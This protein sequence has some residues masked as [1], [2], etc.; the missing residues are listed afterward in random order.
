[1]PLRDDILDPIP[2]DNP[3]GQNLRLRPT[4]DRV[5]EARRE[6]DSLAQGAWRRERKLAD[7][8]MAIRVLQEALA[9]ESKDLQLAAWLCDSLLK[10]EGIRGLRDGI[11]FCQALLERYWDTL[12]PLI[13]D[14]DLDDRVAPFEWVASKLPIGIR[15]LPLCR[16]GFSFLEYTD[17]R[18]IEYEEQAKSKDQKA[19][20]EKALKDGKLAPELF[21][22]SFAETPKAFYADLEMQFDSAVEAVGR[23]NETCAARF[24]HRAAP[25]FTKL[26]DALQEVR[27]V[28]HQLLQKKREIEPDAAEPVPITASTP[29]VRPEPDPV[30]Q[31]A[32]TSPRP[33]PPSAQPALFSAQSLPDSAGDHHETF[34]VIAAAAAALRRRDPFSPAPYLLLRGLRWGELRGSHDPAALE[35]PPREVRRQIKRLAL[36]NQWREMLELAENVM[37]FPYSGAWLDLQRFVVE[38]CAALGEEYNNIAIAI[39]SEIRTLLRDLPQLMDAI[40]NDDTPAA[41]SETQVWLKELLNEPAAP[42][43]QSGAHWFTPSEDTQVPGWRRKYVDAHLRALE[44]MQAGEVPAAIRI[45]QQALEQQSS[46]RGRFR[47]KLQL[48]QLCLSA[49]KDAIAQP[50]LDDIAAEIEAHKLDDWEERELVAGALAFLLQSS[51]RVQADAKTK[52]AMFERIC[53]LDPAKAMSI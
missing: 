32:N 14:G 39:R 19:S 7:H 5:R 49:G 48:A 50:L 31:S 29:A 26:Q 16:A 51:K 3:S 13:E 10:S 20:R 36:D 8:A 25:S 1:M 2:G 22:K 6:D 27:R 35:A 53:R 42:P 47:R 17:S 33:T 46:G 28:V 37:T 9:T 44:A 45:M 30:P 12:F 11:E 23:L 40:L 38:A 24:G 34:S 21:D 4:Y 15:S 43:L 52:Q 41:N 18:S